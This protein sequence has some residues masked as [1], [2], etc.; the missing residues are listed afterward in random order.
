MGLS[1]FSPGSLASIVGVFKAAVTRN[2]N[3]TRN[4]QPSIWQRN[5][6]EHIIRDRESHESV[7]NYILDNPSQWSIDRE[8]PDAPIHMPDPDQSPWW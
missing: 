2:I 8:T 3:Q 4:R 1:E 6:Y 7:R 5:Y